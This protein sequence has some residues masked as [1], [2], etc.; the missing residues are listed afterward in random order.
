MFLRQLDHFLSSHQEGK[1]ADHHRLIEKPFLKDY[2]M[3]GD[4][5]QWTLKLFD[6]GQILELIRRWYDHVITN[7]VKNNCEQIYQYF[8]STIFAQIVE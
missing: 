3:F 5:E 4:M 8:I 1:P 2:A 7:N 6:D